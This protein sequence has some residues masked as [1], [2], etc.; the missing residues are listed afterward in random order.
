[1][2]RPED[3]DLIQSLKAP[4]K[5][6]ERVNQV[7]SELREHPA[8]DLSRKQ[9]KQMAKESRDILGGLPISPISAA[10][11]SLCD[12]IIDRVA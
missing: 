11:Y 8:L 1:M 3:Y 6:G 7:L 9:L 5:D 4:I 12:S 10:F 2:N